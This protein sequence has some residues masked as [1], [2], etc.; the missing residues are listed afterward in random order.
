MSYS[1]FAR[2]LLALWLAM[3]PA[4][5]ARAGEAI[6]TLSPDGLYYAP[7]AINVKIQCVSD[8]EHFPQT[9]KLYLN[10]ELLRTSACNVPDY[11]LSLP[12]GQYV[13]RT[14]A[15][16]V[17]GHNLNEVLYPFN[18]LIPGD[19][20]PSVTLNPIAAGPYNAPANIALSVTATDSDGQVVS[21]E[22]FANGQSIGGGHRHRLD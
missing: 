22:Y 15:I 6:I 5:S 17:H 16:D 9:V 13:L 2:M 18:V 1:I 19:L 10:D 8:D 20:P 21:V 12:R 4:L 3:A 14:T 7:A 11:A